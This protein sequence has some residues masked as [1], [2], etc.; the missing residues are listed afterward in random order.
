[1]HRASKALFVALALVA[2]RRAEAA[3]TTTECVAAHADGQV[4]RKSG[5]LAE[6]AAQYATCA[7]EACPT[8]VRSDCT[9]L[10]H[11]VD[12]AQPTVIFAVID[13]EGKERKDASI[14]IDGGSSVSLPTAAMALDPGEH[15]LRF[16]LPAGTSRNLRV[17]L[18]EWDK[19]RRIVAEFRAPE[20]AESKTSRLMPPAAAVYVLG[21][22]GVVGLAS[23][24]YFGLAGRSIE[25]DL[26][27]CAPYCA[28]T[29]VDRMR[30]RYLV[31]DLSLLVATVSLAVG[32]YLFLRGHDEPKPAATL[33]L[34]LRIAAGRGGASISA[35]KDF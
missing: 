11:E 8:I 31:A 35:G 27:K 5:R 7:L 17:V 33:P 15:L 30:S 1:M 29:D 32:T 4:L 34:G 6:A 2:A 14:T 3:P 16:A 20:A 24:A 12:T 21:G 19:D 22:L 13:A 10:R 23:F 18:R 25:S 28:Q 26:E 9:E